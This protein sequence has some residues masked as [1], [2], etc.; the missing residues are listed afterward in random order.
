MPKS[1]K[2]AAPPGTAS[3]NYKRNYYFNLNAAFTFAT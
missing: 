3:S 1:K 2:K